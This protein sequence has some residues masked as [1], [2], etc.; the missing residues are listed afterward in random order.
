MSEIQI[1]SLS[2]HSVCVH[3]MMT[4][5]LSVIMGETRPVVEPDHDLVGGYSSGISLLD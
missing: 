4:K 1:S 3:W 5:W 2:F